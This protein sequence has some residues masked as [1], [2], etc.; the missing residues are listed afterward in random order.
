MTSQSTYL[1][2]RK[3]ALDQCDRKPYNF[4]HSF[5]IERRYIETP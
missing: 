4:R 1:L 2:L 5:L 3:I